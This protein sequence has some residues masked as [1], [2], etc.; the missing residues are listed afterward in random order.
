MNLPKQISSFLI[1]LFALFNDGTSFAQTDVKA[2]ELIE[3]KQSKRWML[4][5]QNNTDV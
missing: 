3:D 2:V 4:Y 1:V 5:A